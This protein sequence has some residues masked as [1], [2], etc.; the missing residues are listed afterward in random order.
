LKIISGYDCGIIIYDVT[1][2]NIKVAVDN[3]KKDPQKLK[4]L[5]KNA[6]LA[7]T[8]LNW[9]IEEIKLIDFYSKIIKFYEHR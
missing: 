3:L 2:A 9:Q 5:K 4:K 6:K 1:P 7:S 8:D